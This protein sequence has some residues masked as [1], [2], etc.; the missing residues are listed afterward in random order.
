MTQ[1]RFW[2]KLIKMNV[3]H[4]TVDKFV[5]QVRR[6]LFTGMQRS[7]TGQTMLT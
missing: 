3:K 2:I 4:Q 1:C 5:I 6:Q 7:L